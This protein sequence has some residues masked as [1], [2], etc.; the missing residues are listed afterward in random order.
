M[1]WRV[2]TGRIVFLLCLL[3]ALLPVAARGEVL[4]ELAV[5]PERADAVIRLTF[6]GPV[7]Y[8]RHEVFGDSLVELYFRPLTAEP[9]SSTE[10]RRVPPTASFPGVEVVYPQQPRSQT[11]KL[12]LR[13]TSPLKLRVRPADD[14]A[15]DF[16][17]AGAAARL[18]PA[19]EPPA[20]PVARPAPVPLPPAPVAALPPPPA[21]APAPAKPAAPA[22]AAPAETASVR[23]I[24]RLATFRSLEEMQRASPV[25]GEFANKEVQI[26]Q[27]QRQGRKEYDLVL[28]Y[29]PS[30]EAARAARQRLLQRYP[31]A[32][33]VDLGTPVPALAA[34][35]KPAPAPEATLKPAPTPET[36][37]KPT[38]ETALA[39]APKPT[40]VPAAPALPRPTVPSAPI[41]STEI[42]ASAAELLASARSALEAGKDDPAIDSLNKLLRLPPNSLSRDGQEL[43]GIA[44][45]RAGDVAKARA[46]YE[47]YLK[48][49]PEG[50]G[51]A[52]V[53]AR[54]AALAAVPVTTA[55]ARP[56]RAPQ[57]IVTGA[58]SQYYY[59]GRTKVETAFDTPTTVDRS[60]FSATDQST[61]VTNADLSVRNRSAEADTRFVFRDTNSKA[62]LENQKSYNRLTA[63]YYDYRGL[64]NGFSTRVG[65][66][67]GL[68]GGLP[69]RFDGAVAGYGIAPKWRV[70]AAAGMPV[71]YP[72]LDAERYFWSANLEYQNLADAWS[73]NFYYVQQSSDGLL[74]RRAAGT[75]VRYFKGGTS[76]FSVLDYDTSYKQWNV[77]MVQATYQTEGRTTINLLYDKRRAPTLS[78]T[79][80]IFGQGTTSLT[81]LLQTFTEDQLRQQALDVTA[82]ATQGLVGFTTPVGKKWQLGADARLTKVGALPSVE[83]NGIVIPAQPA[84]GDIY[85]YSLQA[86]G[87]NLYSERDTSVYN[88]TYLDGPTQT[89]YQLSYNNLTALG[90]W[91]LEPSLRYYTQKD[92]QNVELKRWTPTLR[93]TYQ[94]VANV[95]LESEFSLEK[96]VTVGPGSRDDTTRGFYYLGYR[97]NF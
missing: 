44:R 79:N 47:L 63:A 26:A 74:D 46:E 37:P 92:T 68:S 39:A 3:P 10:A 70:N 36:A 91:T 18:A 32:E 61:L 54:L 41:A 20:V 1:R 85:N 86:I 95:A 94:V 42:E 82:T 24:I 33:V 57:R 96:T 27:A 45:E 71:E 64:Q 93:I 7:Q 43:M 78:T 87:T 81:T 88:V 14:H 50:A 6:S 60:S 51:A 76:L 38:P 28:G 84:T 17:V 69:G 80:S 25:P 4:D 53:Q 9:T 34:A 58:L 66:Q 31:R 59:G 22:P 97:W 40:P 83:V 65:R 16:V 35:S 15:I 73:G 2:L 77:T 75:E 67:S 30:A 21:P 13:L 23:Y 55:A 12:T 62:F 19:G 72:Q 89:G 11:R 5:F 29:F 48:L 52:R 56:A 90:G 8:L 49:Y